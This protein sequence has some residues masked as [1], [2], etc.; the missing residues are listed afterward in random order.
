MSD[1]NNTD[2][3]ETAGAAASGAD[4]GGV[5]AVESAG[6]EASAEGSA[7][8]DPKAFFN[9]N[10]QVNVVDPDHDGEAED[11][12]SDDARAFQEQIPTE[13]EDHEALQAAL[14]QGATTF[15]VFVADDVKNSFI[16][17][18][19]VTDQDEGG[20]DASVLK[21]A[22]RAGVKDEDFAENGVVVDFPVTEYPEFDSDLQ[23]ALESRGYGDDPTTLAGGGSDDGS[24][25]HGVLVGVSKPEHLQRGDNVVVAGRGVR[26]LEVGSTHFTAVNAHGRV[27][28]FAIEDIA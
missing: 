19:L 22:Q 8:V 10:D 3:T 9:E 15:R 21:T 4:Q 17:D 11:G 12:L 13:E 2:L 18:D 27:M 25:D 24:D 23:A 28:R 16:I 14:A 7:L 6:L 26:V 5:V 1:A 20:D